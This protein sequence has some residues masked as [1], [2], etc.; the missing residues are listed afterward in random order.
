MTKLLE[1]ALG[2]VS[3]LS[4]EEQD[5]IARMMLAMSGNDAPETIDPAHLSAVLEGLDQ[6]SRGEFAT[7]EEVAAAFRRFEA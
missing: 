7:E 4:A 2:A 6:A 1:Q 5:E 3:A